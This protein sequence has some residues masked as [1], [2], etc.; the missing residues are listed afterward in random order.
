MLAAK[1]SSWC[2]EIK[3]HQKI[4]IFLTLG[5][6]ADYSKSCLSL[7]GFFGEF[8]S[9]LLWN[10]IDQIVISLAVLLTQIVF[11]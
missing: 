2:P 1:D 4:K 11:I 8:A 3:N 6:F 9:F 5:S 7:F 10:L